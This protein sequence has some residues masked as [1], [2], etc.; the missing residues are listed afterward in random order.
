MKVQINVT[1][2]FFRFFFLVLFVCHNLHSLTAFAA[3]AEKFYGYLYFG[4][5]TNINIGNKSTKSEYDNFRAEHPNVKTRGITGMKLVGYAH[6]SNGHYLGAMI[7]GSGYYSKPNAGELMD[8]SIGRFY[9]N[10]LQ[11]LFSNNK[12]LFIEL[13]SGVVLTEYGK[14]RAEDATSTTSGKWG[15]GASAGLGYEFRPIKWLGLNI[16][17][18]YNFAHSPNLGNVTWN[19]YGAAVSLSF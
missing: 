16:Q 8:I 17:G 2:S 12:G 11:F 10:Y 9:A 14:K 19:D 18:E 13:S 6:K 7:A 1:T 15:Y 4:H 3:G 5:D